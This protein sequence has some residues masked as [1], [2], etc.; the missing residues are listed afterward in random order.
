MAEVFFQRRAVAD[1]GA[2]FVLQA[3]ELRDEFVFELAFG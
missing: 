1:V 2:M 3:D